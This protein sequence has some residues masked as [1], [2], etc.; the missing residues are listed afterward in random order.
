MGTLYTVSSTDGSI[1]TAGAI[2]STST[3]HGFQP[4]SMTTTQRNAIPTPADGL[5]VYDTTLH[6]LWEYQNGAWAEVGGGGST[7]PAGANTQ[8]QFNNSGVFGA[9]SNFTW[10]NGATTLSLIG[11]LPILSLRSDTEAAVA[12]QSADGLTTFGTL[13]DLGATGIGLSHPTLVDTNV[14]ALHLSVASTQAFVTDGPDTPDDP[15][16]IFEITSTTKGFLPPRL[17]TSQRDAIAS[18]ATGLE[19]YNTDTND[20]EKWDSTSWK[21][22]GSVTSNEKIYLG[23][24]DNAWI[25][26]DTGINQLQFHSKA[27]NVAQNFTFGAGEAVDATINLSTLNGGT[28]SVS[29]ENSS[30][31]LELFAGTSNQINLEG[32]VYVDPNENDILMDASAALQIDSTTQGFLPPRVTTTQ[33]DAISTPATGLQIYNTT[34]NQSEFY[35][36]TIWTSGGGGGSPG[37]ANTDIQFNN[38]GAFGGVSTLTWDGTSVSATGLSVGN[39]IIAFPGGDLNIQTGGNLAITDGSSFDISGGGNIFVTGGQLQASTST[40]SSN[41]SAL[42]QLDS[43]TQGFLPPRM[44]TTQRNAISSP[45][46][47]L[48]VYNTTLNETD[49]YNGTSWVSIGNGNF[50][51]RVSN[52]ALTA[53]P[54]AIATTT[55]FTPTTTGTYRV[56]VYIVDTAAG[57]AGTVAATI[58]WTDDEQAQ[59]ISTSTVPLATLGAF[60]NSTFFIEATSGNN[61]TYATTFVGALGSPQYSLYVTAERLS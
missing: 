54:S 53:Q 52:V 13:I 51:S 30:G 18:P 23:N 27:S 3:T 11:T 28:A 25:K 26:F 56:S 44:T 50:P 6:Q 31:F 34:T 39:G 46:T 45:A 40:F 24:S 58:G 32:H 47:G 36:G 21:S 20:V 14:G 60:T 5:I 37:G 15:S 22:I 49:V 4:P 43:T 38:S 19:I 48:V 12:F 59:T 16:A 17:T 33:R 8:V 61:V 2:T 57:S 35:N 9:S 7:P 41:P 29:L 10:D 42:C 1:T 55:L